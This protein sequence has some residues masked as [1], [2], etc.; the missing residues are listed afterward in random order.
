MESA[1]FF[2]TGVAAQNSALAVHAN[3]PFRAY[4]TENARPV[5]HIARHA[6]SAA[7]R[8][9]AYSELLG[10]NALIAGE[11]HRILT[12]DDIAFH[13]KRLAAVGTAPCMILVEQPHVSLVAR[14]S[15]GLS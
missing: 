2:P 1:V 13:L 6:A 14:R 4:R 3:L 11:P 15:N 7:L 8:G 12:A 9:E 10:L 5:S